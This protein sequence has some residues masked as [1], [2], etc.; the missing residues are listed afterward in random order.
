MIYYYDLLSHN[1]VQYSNIIY[2]SLLKLLLF[3]IFFFV[4]IVVAAVVSIITCLVRAYIGQTA[5]EEYNSHQQQSCRRA[6]GVRTYLKSSNTI[7]YGKY[8][9][10]D[11]RH[12]TAEGSASSYN[13]HYARR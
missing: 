3:I 9:L 1:T 11:R 12:C 10:H 2:V 6:L 7:K 13:C 5:W 4:S 8:V